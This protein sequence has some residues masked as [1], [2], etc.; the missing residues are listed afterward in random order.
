MKKTLVVLGNGPSLKN[1]DF[2]KL[3]KF[4]TFAMNGAFLNFE[5][6]QFYPN[7]WGCFP[8][9]T[10]MWEPDEINNF[11]SKDF[12][13]IDKFFTFDGYY[14]RFLESFQNPCF[15]NTDK[16]IA[17]KPH[18][19]EVLDIDI[20]KW[21]VPWSIES[22]LFIGKII[23]EYGEEKAK[24]MLIDFEKH[25]NNL[26][27]IKEFNQNGLYKFLHKTPLTQDDYIDKPRWKTSWTL[28]KSF[29][30]FAF[31]GGNSAIIA[32]LIGY[33]MGYKRVIL[34]GV[35]CNWKTNGNIVDTK[36]SYWFDNYFNNREYN[37]KDF[38]SSCNEDSIHK[39]HFDSWTNLNE[40]I[41]NNK[42]DFQVL[43]GNIESQLKTFEFVNI[44]R[45]SND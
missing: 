13:K 27:E 8:M 2:S 22:N 36:Q 37:I 40:M 41:T 11:I 42:L 35:D 21:S 18:I 32:T 38:C 44:E 16:F 19:P 14:K 45:L 4:D 33:I 7:F 29:D 20:N 6:I 31:S 5:K 17:I 1:V 9:G 39:M 30:D 28:P 34:L 10:M 24:I 15:L 3:S 25:N 43:N 26:S 12:S 23:Q